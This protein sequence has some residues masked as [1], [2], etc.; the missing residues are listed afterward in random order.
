MSLKDEIVQYTDADGLVNPFP[1]SSSDK[2]RTGN[3]LAYTAL[4]YWILVKRGEARDPALA[5]DFMAVYDR[6]RF[7]GYCGLLYRAPE[8]IG[9]QDGWDDYIC[10]MAAGGVKAMNLLFTRYIEQHA[11]SH[12]WCFND[13]NP[14]KFSFKSFFGRSPAF[15][16]HVA[17]CLG[18]RPFVLWR[19][20]WAV[21]VATAGLS[22]TSIVLHELMID[23]M[24]GLS[25]V[26]AF[27]AAI[28][29]YRR[30]KISMK[31]AIGLWVSIEKDENGNPLPNLD[32]PLVKYWIGG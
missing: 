29:D 27:G 19:L 17:F 32:H 5:K 31:T 23:A 13:E 11:L 1:V 10:L 6:C 24:D 9:D 20:G 12:F 3:G 22:P 4:Y 21:M 8:K 25:G 28:F 26:C 14:D 30:R 16:A 2:A 15:R 7:P 18:K